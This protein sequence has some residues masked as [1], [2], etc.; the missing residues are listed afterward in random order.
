MRKFSIVG[1]IEKALSRSFDS[2]HLKSMLLVISYPE[3][4]LTFSLNPHLFFDL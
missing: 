3:L 1:P 2:N 4:R